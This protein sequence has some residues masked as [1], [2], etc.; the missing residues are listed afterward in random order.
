[1]KRS[2]QDK[3]RLFINDKESIVSDLR[4]LHR[5]LA[6]V[7]KSQLAEVQLVRGDYPEHNLF[8]LFN[9]DRAAMSYT[10]NIDEAFFSARDSDVSTDERSAVEFRF[11]NGEGA[12]YPVAETIRTED[13]LKS[14]EYFFQK[15][16][17]P[18]W[19]KWHKNP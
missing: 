16:E 17:L 8:A 9:G 19:I 11:S 15:E 7:R 13:A 14:F 3:W 5:R 12:E 18:P 4:G 1:M 2:S 6:A 10:L